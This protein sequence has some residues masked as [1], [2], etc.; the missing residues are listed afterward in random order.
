EVE[1]DEE[2]D[3]GN[4]VD[5]DECS[6]AC[7]VATCGDGIVQAVLGETCDDGN[8]A[9]GD[10]CSSN[11]VLPG[12]VI[13][14]KLLP[15]DCDVYRIALAEPGRFYLGCRKNNEDSST[16]LAFDGDGNQL[17]DISTIGEPYYSSGQ[18]LAAGPDNVF[19]VAGR[20]GL[21]GQVRHFDA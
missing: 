8:T 7:A 9:S 5:D 10:S 18:W 21:Q 17:W 11:C 20:V 3:D 12:T 4:Q 2:C 15:V 13:W 14:E 16:V 6:N 19:A 1:G